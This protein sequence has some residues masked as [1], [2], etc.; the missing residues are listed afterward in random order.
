M[1]TD[2][3]T[4]LSNYPSVAIYKTY[5]AREPFDIQGDGFTL[6]QKLKNEVK[7]LFYYDDVNN[8]LTC[9]KKYKT[10]FILGAGDLYDKVL[11]GLNFKRR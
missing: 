10:V 2:F 11:D 9:S 6:Y 8:L 3:A 1:L 5:P 4:V 7:N